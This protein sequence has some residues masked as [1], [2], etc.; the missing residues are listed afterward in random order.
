MKKIPYK[1]KGISRHTLIVMAYLAIIFV[2]SGILITRITGSGDSIPETEFE[3]E[4]ES[5]IN[6]EELFDSV[7]EQANPTEDEQKD[8]ISDFERDNDEEPDLQSEQQTLPEEHMENENTETVDK[9]T[10][11]SQDKQVEPISAEKIPQGIWPVQGEIIAGHGTLY[12]INNQYRFHNGIDIEANK[13]QV[14]RAAWSGKVEQIIEDPALGLK[15]KIASEG[16][17]T[18][19]A[20]LRST[21]VSEGDYISAGDGIATVG[22][23]AKLDISEGFYL[24]FAVTAGKNSI[25][26]EQ[27]LPDDSH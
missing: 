24:H 20:N 21:E 16:Y 2:M 27:L 17:L 26:P 15:I 6:V 8:S 9:S 5:A 4:P 3:Q 7:S 18:T 22:D 19:Y 23:S 1:L 12:Q 10:E 11:E 14:V 13:G 25:D